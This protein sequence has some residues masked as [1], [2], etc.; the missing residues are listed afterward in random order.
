MKHHNNQRSFYFA[1]KIIL[2]YSV[3]FSC[4]L[5]SFAQYHAG[6]GGRAGK[7]NSGVTMKYFFQP[8]NAT[9]ISLLIAHSKIADGGWVISPMYEHQVPFHIP[10]IQLPLDFIV[11]MGMHMGYYHTR[12]YKIVDGLPDYYKN[13]TVTVGVDALVALEYE[14][15]IKWMHLAIGIEAQPFYEFVNKGP[16][17]LDFGATL[18]YV[19]QE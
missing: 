7:F 14:V 6:I 12:Y 17:F 15:P 9:G 4:S 19:F 3:L 8:D 10:I 11:G 1:A 16:E 2:I 13:N 5:T 18:K